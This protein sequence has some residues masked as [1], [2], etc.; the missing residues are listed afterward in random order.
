MIHGVEL[1]TNAN[2]MVATDLVTDSSTFTFV[3]DMVVITPQVFKEKKKRRKIRCSIL[4]CSGRCSCCHCNFRRLSRGVGVVDP[5]SQLRTSYSS[6]I[7]CRRRKAGS[8]LSGNRASR[9]WLASGALSE[10]QARIPLGRR[11]CHN[12]V[13]KYPT[14]IWKYHGTLPVIKGA[15][16]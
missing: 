2:D 8:L 9:C 7:Q 12:H 14:Q 6:G 4:Q 11:Y 13:I 5:P 10:E 1:I 15:V 3:K 16:G